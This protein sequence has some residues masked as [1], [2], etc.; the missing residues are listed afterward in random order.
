MDIHARNSVHAQLDVV[1]RL[2]QVEGSVLGLE[3]QRTE[4]VL[5]LQPADLPTCLTDKWYSLSPDR[6]Q[7]NDAYS[8]SVKSAGSVI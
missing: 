7:Q 3:Q 2:K 6:E 4:R 1:L 8:S 5:K